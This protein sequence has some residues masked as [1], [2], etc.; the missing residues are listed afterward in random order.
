[1]NL[2]GKRGNI[3]AE[4]F[5]NSVEEPRHPLVRI[6]HIDKEWQ[7]FYWN[8]SNSGK[9][10]TPLSLPKAIEK[11]NTIEFDLIISEPLN[12]GILKEERR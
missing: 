11:L 1:L 6:L 7:V 5:D 8:I 12:L 10:V 3:M 9:M 2:H 4:D